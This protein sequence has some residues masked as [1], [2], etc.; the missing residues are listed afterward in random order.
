MN[1]TW[2][3]QSILNCQLKSEVENYLIKSSQIHSWSFDGYQSNLL[4]GFKLIDQRDFEPILVKLPDLLAKN[5]AQLQAASE[6]TQSESEAEKICNK[7]DLVSSQ[8]QVSSD[9]DL[10]HQNLSETYEKEQIKAQESPVVEILKHFKHIDDPRADA[11]RQHKLSDIIAIAILAIIC[12]ADHWNQIEK[13]GKAKRKWL[14]TFLELPAGIPSHDTF[15]RVF[16]RL[17]PDQFRSG[18][19][20]WVNSIRKMI[21]GEIIAI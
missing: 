16:A 9:S 11:N 12:G 15:N 8:D 5:L 18:F 19:I 6:Q 21:P 20:S 10:A 7:K 13:F 1:L 17:D 2:T 3:Q 14:S 4:L